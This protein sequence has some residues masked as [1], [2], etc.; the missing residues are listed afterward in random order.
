MIS[1]E[2]ETFFDELI[3]KLEKRRKLYEEGKLDD[4]MSEEARQN[5]IEKCN[6]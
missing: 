2:L 4:G 3:D 1:K 5:W 6:S